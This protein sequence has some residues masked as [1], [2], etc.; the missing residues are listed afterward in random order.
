MAQPRVAIVG[1]GFGGLYAAKALQGQPVD[2]LLVD[3]LNYHLFQPL[4][5]QV[6]TAGLEPEEIAYPVRRILQR[7]PNVE[8][9]M[10][11]VQAI[12]LAQRRLQTDTGPLDYDYLIL[13]AGSENNFFGMDELAAHACGLKDLQ[14]AEDL[15][16]HVLSCFEHAAPLPPSP[17]REALLTFVIGGGGPTG[18][19][20]AGALAEL[21]SLVLSHDYR[22]AIR[23]DEVHLILLE[24]G[25][26]L[27]ESF[28]PVSRR[29]AL[30]DLRRK[31]IDVRLR[32]HVAGYDGQTVRLSD[33]TGITA[34]T[35]MWAA[36]VRASSLAETTGLKLAHGGRL[37]VRP[38]LQ[39]PDH[40][41][42]YVIGDMAYLEERG[43]PLPQLAPVAM[44]QAEVA[45]ENIVR[46]VHGIPPRVFHYRDKGTLATIGRNAAVTE[47]PSGTRFKGPLAWYMWLVLH[48]AYIIGF[49]S[50]VAVL[51]NWIWSYF[52]YDRH[53]RIIVSVEPSPRPVLEAPPRR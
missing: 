43:R 5:Y 18:V 23:P 22:G 41:E 3:R 30:A 17:E 50:R 14:Q 31:R 6:A 38:S 12:E 10:A 8:F 26:D 25:A 51:V 49:R 36:G 19:E 28:H 4:L 15:R 7:G 45:A 46:D 29:A 9:R 37:P 20:F 34:R 32:Q 1:A 21:T 52:T 33:G 48:L 35:L 39:L 2:V 42:V 47:L 44:Q 13:A 27:L 24:G 16:N 11:R 53:A 40:P